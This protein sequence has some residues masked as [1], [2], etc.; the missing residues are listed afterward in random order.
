MD[1][2]D[3]HGSRDPGSER[4]VEQYLYDLESDSYELVN[5]VELDAFDAAK[6]ELRERL[7]RRMVA[8]GEPAPLIEPASS[9]PS[10]QRR[11]SIAQVREWHFRK[12]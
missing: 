2:P 12:A 11:P 10:G 5:L 4:Y 8:A 7:I 3:K 1:A 9:Q 6:A